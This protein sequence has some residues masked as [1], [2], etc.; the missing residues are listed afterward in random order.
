[1][2]CKHAD[3][4]VSVTP[5]RRVEP[6]SGRKQWLTSSNIGSNLRNGHPITARG[7]QNK[8][9]HS[10]AA[11]RKLEEAAVS[12]QSWIGEGQKKLRLVSHLIGKACRGRRYH[13]TLILA[14]C[15]SYWKAESVPCISSGLM[16]SQ[17]WP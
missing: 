14:S 12:C 6:I 1:M 11:S 5:V 17:K 10:V 9:P 15:C 16:E 7:K 3:T 2:S 13:K 4:M 8:P